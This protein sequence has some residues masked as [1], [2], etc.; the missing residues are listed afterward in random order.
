MPIFFGYFLKA[1]EMILAKEPSQ[2]LP[3]RQDGRCF[4]RK[5]CIAGSVVSISESANNIGHQ[6]FHEVSFDILGA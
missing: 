1:S 5:Y 3:A 2:I 6:T 4:A